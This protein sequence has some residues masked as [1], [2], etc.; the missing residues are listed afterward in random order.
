M[1]HAER[2]ELAELLSELTPQQWKHATLC[3]GWCVRELVAHVVS[4]DDLTPLSYAKRQ[5]KARFDMDRFNA[6]GVA[7]YATYTP[8]RMCQVMREHLHPRG[9]MA[10]FGGI[11]GLLDAMIHQQDIRRP[12]GIPRT[13]PAPRLRAALGYAMYVPVLRGAWRCRGLRLIATDVDWAH[14]RGPEVRA[15]GE[16]ALMTLAGRGPACGGRNGSAS[17]D[18]GGERPISLWWR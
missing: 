12:L 1:A 8:A 18:L 5:V 7:T 3:E 9:Y 4:Y 16:A 15:D 17:L 10:A 2:K 14:G 13:I 11:I 6:I